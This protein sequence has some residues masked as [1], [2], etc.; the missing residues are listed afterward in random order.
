MDAAALSENVSR[1]FGNWS[2][3]KLKDWLRYIRQ[4]NW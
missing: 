3:S 4:R 2:T 1:Q